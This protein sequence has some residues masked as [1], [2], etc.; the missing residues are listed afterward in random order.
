MPSQT[1]PGADGGFQRF[2]GKVLPEDEL[3]DLRDPRKRSQRASAPAPVAPQ[4]NLPDD[5]IRRIAEIM[6]SL[7]IEDS[8]EGADERTPQDMSHS[9]IAPSRPLDDI[10]CTLP[11]MV[12]ALTAHAMLQMSGE[13]RKSLSGAASEVAA[14]M[15]EQTAALSGAM[16][17]M[18]GSKVEDAANLSQTLAMLETV[19]GTATELLHLKDH[20]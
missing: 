13:Q 2:L 8:E 17:M 6:D 1:V 3:G 4:R 16:A 14:A 15:V 19:L 7:H 20:V 9:D 10:P 11:G 18:A 5:V 12:R